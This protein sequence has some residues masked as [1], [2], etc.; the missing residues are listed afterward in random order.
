MSKAKEH[1]YEKLRTKLLETNYFS[2]SLTEKA[3]SLKNQDAKS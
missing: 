2:S 1:F 3:R